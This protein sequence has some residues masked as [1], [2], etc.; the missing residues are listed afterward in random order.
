MH[1]TNQKI[2]NK[3]DYLSNILLLILIILFNKT[4]I[5]YAANI[6]WIEVSKTPAGIQYIDRD[7]IDIKGEKIIQ[8]TT[9]YLKIDSNTSKGIEENVYTM[10]INCLTKKF[11]DISVNGKKNL[12]AK[13]EDP[14]GDKLIDD[15]I[16]DS[17]ENV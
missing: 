17:C 5:V 12:T 3:L 10:E 2:K 8:L 4:N 11:K 1:K 13:W 15:V 7:S 16:T 6:N 9:K 14:N